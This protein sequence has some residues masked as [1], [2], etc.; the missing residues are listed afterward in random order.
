MQSVYFLIPSS[1]VISCA[2]SI[3]SLSSSSVSFFFFQSPLANTAI[4]IRAIVI[5]EMGKAHHNPTCC[6]F[7][8]LEST[9]ASG[10][11]NTHCDTSVSTIAT[12]IFPEARNTPVRLNCS[13]I[14]PHDKHVMRRK[15]LAPLITFSSSG[16]KKATRYGAVKKTIMPIPVS[17]QKPSVAPSLATFAARG[18]LSAPMF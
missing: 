15:T 18:I 13:H 4:V 11:C 2:T 8:L 10:N 7:V 17:I 5:L 16:T 3:A 12:I 1:A 9:Y 14:N 6:R